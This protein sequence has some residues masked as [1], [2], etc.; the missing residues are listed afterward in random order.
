MR[1]HRAQVVIEPL[2]SVV[3]VQ[4]WPPWARHVSQFIARIVPQGSGLVLC[5]SAGVGERLES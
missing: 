3:V 2:V 5:A 4:R 1:P